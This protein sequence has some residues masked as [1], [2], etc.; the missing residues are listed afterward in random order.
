MFVI[1]ASWFIAVDSVLK[2]YRLRPG[3]VRSGG[4]VLLITAIAL[5]SSNGLACH[6]VLNG[7]KFNHVFPYIFTLE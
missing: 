7:L 5:T 3:D 2:K 6:I 4:P 1:L